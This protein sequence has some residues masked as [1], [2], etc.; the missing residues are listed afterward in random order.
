MR[1]TDV[2]RLAASA[3]LSFFA[4][5]SPDTDPAVFAYNLGALGIAL[6]CIYWLLG[7]G[8]RREREQA[9]EDAEERR[10]LREMLQHERAA[11][12]ETRKALIE[13]LRRRKEDF[14]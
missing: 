9:I 13:S 7:R 2:L 10:H 3:G 5:T 12:D 4:V 8:D 11:H 14:T 6:G 1:A